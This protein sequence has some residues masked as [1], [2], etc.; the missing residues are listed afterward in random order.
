MEFQTFAVT[1]HIVS[2]ILWV[3]GGM[4]LLL[5][6]EMARRKHG[7]AGA[8]AIVDVVALMGPVYF[9]PVSLLTVLSGAAAAWFGPGFGELWVVLGL[10]GFA[11]TF[12]TGLLVIKPRAEAIAVLAS[13]GQ[14]D[15]GT[16]LGKSLDLLTIARFDYV[17]LFLVV[18]VM[19]LKPAASETALLAGFA[20][21]AA[22]GAMFTLVKGMRSQGARA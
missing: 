2:V 8:L 19:V 18:L 17:V 14:V 9:V 10:V 16:L 1:V 5:G 11:V 22:I 7:D 13:D 4:A 12:L 20:A 21:V 15:Q 3:G 6:A